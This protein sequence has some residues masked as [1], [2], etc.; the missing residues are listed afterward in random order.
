MFYYGTYCEG[1]HVSA[2]LDTLLPDTQV[3]PKSEY[4]DEQLSITPFSDLNILTLAPES[5]RPQFEMLQ[6][7]KYTAQRSS[8]YLD[9]QTAEQNLSF[10]QQ[11]AQSTNSSPGITF[12]Q[13]LFASLETRATPERLSIIPFSDHNTTVCPYALDRFPPSS[14]SCTSD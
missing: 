8:Q 6:T 4:T 12:S 14:I 5:E 13:E 10:Q 9:M 2:D 7:E 11:L 3:D 1:A